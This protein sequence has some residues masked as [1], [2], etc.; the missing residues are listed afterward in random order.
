VPVLTLA[1]E[2]FTSRVATSLLHAVGLGSLSVASRAEYVRRAVGL[3]SDPARLGRLRVHLEQIRSRSP[4]FDT[5]RYCRHLE[6]AYAEICARH[7]R[8]EAPVDVWVTP[9]A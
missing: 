6:D 9:R 5:A 3:A 8:G 2:T 4:L 1:G 7:Q